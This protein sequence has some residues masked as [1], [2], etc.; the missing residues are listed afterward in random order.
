MKMVHFQA[1]FI[2][3]SRS[4]PSKKLFSLKIKYE[5]ET[6]LNTKLTWMLLYFLIIMFQE[7]KQKGE[8]IPS[9]S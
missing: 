6:G 8:F 9:L 5:S 7:R 4:V 3:I 2:E 1:S